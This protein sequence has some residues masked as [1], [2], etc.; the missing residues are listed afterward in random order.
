LDTLGGQRI[1]IAARA[2]DVVWPPSLTSA[3]YLD[4]ST[5][6]RLLRKTG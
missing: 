5:L 1:L 6:H 3:T 2:V 4:G